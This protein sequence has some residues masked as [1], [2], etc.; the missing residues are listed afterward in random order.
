ML[1]DSPLSLP[2]E[3]TTYSRTWLK[4]YPVCKCF[5]GLPVLCYSV[6]QRS[7]FIT[8]TH[9][10]L[11]GTILLSARNDSWCWDSRDEQIKSIP[12]EN[13]SAT[14][15]KLTY[16]KLLHKAEL[17]WKHQL[18]HLYITSS[19]HTI[20]AKDV[21]SVPDEKS[22]DGKSEDHILTTICHCDTLGFTLCQTMRWLSAPCSLRVYWYMSQYS[23]FKWE[24]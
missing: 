4:L 1:A 20:G 9:Q 5:L 21:H 14:L 17:P 11:S 12:W 22:L 7:A 10:Q 15:N 6:A 2:Q 23:D 18:R 3:N 19:W 16:L 13:H 8:F 24:R